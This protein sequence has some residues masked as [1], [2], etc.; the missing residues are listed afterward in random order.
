LR[1]GAEPETE[2]TAEVEETPETPAAEAE[3]VAASIATERGVTFDKDTAAQLQSDAAAGREART[4]QL[5]A[6]RDGIIETALK[7]GKFPPVAAAS[8][9][10]QLDQGGDVEAST[11][12]FIDDLEPGT[13]PVSEIGASATHEAGQLEVVR[14]SF[15]LPPK[16][17]A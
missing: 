9:R 8:Y 12:K 13:V 7:A 17:T 6:E 5:K 16:Q 1:V 4:T 14:A 15:G 3:P 10:K 2:E 11:R